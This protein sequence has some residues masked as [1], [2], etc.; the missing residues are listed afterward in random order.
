VRKVKSLDG[1]HV[2]VT[3][4]ASG[5]G[6][7]LAADLL[8]E[9][10]CN[11]ILVD[12]NYSRLQTLRSELA[13]AAVSRSAGAKTPS[14]PRT[15]SIH[16]CDIGSRVSVQAFLA[17]LGERQVDIL[18]NNAGIA[19]VGSFEQADMDDIE[20]IVEVNLLGTLRLTKALLP[21][22]LVSERGF[23][24]NVASLAGLM[25]SPGMSAY[26]ASKAGIVGFSASLEIELDGQAGVCAVCP[27]FVKTNIAH[28]ALLTEPAQD[29]VER[30]SAM[31]AA[32]ERMGAEPEKVSRA[33]IRAVKEN[34]RLVL[35]NAD[36]RLLHLLHRFFPALSRAVVSQA[37]RKMVNEGLVD[38]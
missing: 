6:K 11:L 15:V 37:Y 7:Q 21:R 32:L 14:D 27:A 17:D 13:S 25:A 29:R 16:Y 36:A 10:G 35:V 34:R 24:V 28:N 38:A 1:M 20:R 5:I 26:A 18:V 23:I 22:I 30:L 9:E 19:Q 8:I 33:V 31:N 12:Q 2:L 3:G 4:A